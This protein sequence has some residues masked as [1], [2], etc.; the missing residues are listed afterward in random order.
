MTDTHNQTKTES[1]LYEFWEKE[2]LFKAAPSSNKKPYSLLMPPP[3][4]N[5]ELH[6]GHAMEHSIMDA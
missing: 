1:E 3:N 6:L 4:V 5:G 2:S